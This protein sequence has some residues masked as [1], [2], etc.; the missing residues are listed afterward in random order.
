MRPSEQR[1]AAGWMEDGQAACS[2]IA[3]GAFEMAD[4]S[5]RA[6]QFTTTHLGPG[7]AEERARQ[8]RA[9]WQSSGKVDI[10]VGHMGNDATSL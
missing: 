6:R 3:S 8:V 10:G 5:R 2:H 9:A 7:V 1:A 4:L